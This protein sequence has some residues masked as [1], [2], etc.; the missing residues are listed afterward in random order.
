M[1]EQQHEM[2][3]EKTHASGAEEWFC[4]ICARR[5]LLRVPPTNDMI[6]LE[7]GNRYVSHSGSVG[8]LR[9]GLVQIAQ[10]DEESDDVTEESLRPWIKALKDLDLDW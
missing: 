3:L 10:Q 6:V 1:N 2:V 7:P 8:G 5:F 9:I 4:P